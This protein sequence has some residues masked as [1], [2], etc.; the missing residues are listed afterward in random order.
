M[1]SIYWVI[2][3]TSG[4]VPVL[5]LLLVLIKLLSCNFLLTSHALNDYGG[6]YILVGLCAFFLYFLAAMFAYNPFV[7]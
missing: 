2:Y 5:A 4:A 3:A 7:I 6:A 1:F